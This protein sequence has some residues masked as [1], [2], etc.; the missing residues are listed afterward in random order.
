MFKLEVSI[1]M[2]DQKIFGYKWNGLLRRLCFFLEPSYWLI[3]FQL[4]FLLVIY[5]ATTN[6]NTHLRKKPFHLYRRKFW[7][8]GNSKISVRFPLEIEKFRCTGNYLGKTLDT[9]MAL[10]CSG[11][12]RP[13]WPSA[14]TVAALIWSSCSS[15]STIANWLTP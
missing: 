3:K 7:F 2:V 15:D 12:C 4:Q 6:M 10:A 8:T 11:V 5:F 13:I 1:P 14:H 9:A